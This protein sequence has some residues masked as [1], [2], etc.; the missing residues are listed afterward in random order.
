MFR[1]RRRRDDRW[2][3]LAGDIER[4]TADARRL[5]RL[6]AP[7]DAGTAARLRDAANEAST[8]FYELASCLSVTLGRTPPPPPPRLFDDVDVDEFIATIRRWRRG[9]G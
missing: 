9:D 2:A 7:A 6:G 4:L 8:V 3:A 1:V 5:L